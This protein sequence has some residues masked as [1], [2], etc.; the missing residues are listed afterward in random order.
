MGWTGTIATRYKKG[1]ID[2]KAECDGYFMEGLNAG[3]YEV[4]KSTMRGSVYYAAVQNKTRY[5]G[6]DEKN[7]PV[8]EPIENGAVWAAVFLT[9]V[10]GPWFYYK[11]MSEDMGPCECDC[12]TSILNLLSE[13]DSE[14]ALAWRERCRKSRE[15]KKNPNA[16]NNLPVGAV[17]RFTNWNGEPV[18]LLKHPAA[19]Q[20]KRPF[21]YCEASGGYI[22]AKRIPGNYEVISA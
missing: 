17:I 21:W 20:F 5:V 8:Y 7:K 13:T 6:R 22:P 19:Y 14:Y 9:S 16:L 12:P 4:L 1:I 10:E 18:E 15:E 2:R 11:D 3:H